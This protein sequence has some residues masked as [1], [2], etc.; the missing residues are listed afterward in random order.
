[1]NKVKRLVLISV[2]FMIFINFCLNTQFYPKLLQYQAG[3]NA[4]LLIKKEQ[5]N[6]KDVFMLT[7][8]KTSWSL[9]FYT[10]RIT[11]RISITEISKNIK[12]GQWLFVYEDQIKTLKEN[13]IKWSK[14]YKIDHYRITRLNLKFLNPESRK[15]ILEKAFLLQ[16]N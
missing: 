16:I 12:K 7:E 8:D 1:M 6:P 3:N 15:N 13:N 9:D 2:Y 10:E 4:G 5:I 14:E 11:P